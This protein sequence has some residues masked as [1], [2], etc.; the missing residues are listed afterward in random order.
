VFYLIIV[1]FENLYFI[2]YGSA[3]THLRCGGI[4]SNHV[5]ANGLQN[6]PVKEFWKSVDIWQRHGQSWTFF[7]IQC[8]CVFID[9][10]GQETD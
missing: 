8:R 5:I 7:E 2:R 3:A 4:F 6:V 9:W 10:S 1:I